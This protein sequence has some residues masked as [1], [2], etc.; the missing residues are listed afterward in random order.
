MKQIIK[1]TYFS[2]PINFEWEYKEIHLK[3]IVE[4]SSLF[5]LKVIFINIVVNFYINI[6]SLSN[7]QTQLYFI[8]KL[9]VINLITINKCRAILSDKYNIQ[10]KIFKRNKHYIVQ[11]N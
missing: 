8:I 9:I 10:I 6:N 2:Y 5:D 4:G 11:D 1:N 7:N 3:N